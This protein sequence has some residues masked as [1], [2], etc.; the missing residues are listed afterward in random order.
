MKLV[1]ALIALSSLAASQVTNGGRTHRRNSRCNY[2][3]ELDKRLT[4]LDITAEGTPAIG[5]YFDVMAWYGQSSSY[6]LFVSNR[7]I[8][9]RVG[10]LVFYVEP[11]VVLDYVWKF[12]HY[13]PQFRFNVPYRKE[14]VGRSVYFQWMGYNRHAYRRLEL[15][16]ACAVVLVDG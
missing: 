5:G 15:S 10:P 16:P 2:I 1:V 6:W 7:R 8:R 13:R 3:G 12:G 14:L 9:Y 11:F 4:H